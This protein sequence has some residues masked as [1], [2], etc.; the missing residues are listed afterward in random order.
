MNQTEDKWL[1]YCKP[2]SEFEEDDNRHFIPWR[3]GM[4]YQLEP[5]LKRIAQAAVR[6]KWQP[7]RVRLNAYIRAKQQADQLLGWNARDPRLRSSGAWDCLFRYIL[8][9]LDL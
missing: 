5:D 1:D 8:N 7:F 3:R 2:L 9:E 4:L 6:Q